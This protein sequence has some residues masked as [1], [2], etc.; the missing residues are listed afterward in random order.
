[1]I[2]T[3]KNAFTLTELLVALAVVI[4]LSSLLLGGAM[5]ALDSARQA[6]CANHLR[7]FGNAV[8]THAVDHDNTFMAPGYIKG[9]LPSYWNYRLHNEGYISFPAQRG[10]YCPALYQSDYRVA[11]FT[12]QQWIRAGH[13][14][15]VGYSYNLWLAGKRM[16]SVPELSKTMFFIETH[17][18]NVCVYAKSKPESYSFRHASKLHLLYCDG[19]LAMWEQGTPFPPIDNTF[20]AY[21][22]KP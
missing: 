16:A 12:E 2:S 10:L 22:P 3:T 1:M 8:L 17:M 6:G 9:D 7:T 11:A 19:S 15:S 21:P 18:G 4:V 5:K 13:L 20:W 14:N